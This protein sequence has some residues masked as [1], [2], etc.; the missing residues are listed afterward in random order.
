MGR[1]GIHRVIAEAVTSEEAE[2]VT[3]DIS[4]IYLRLVTAPEQWWKENELLSIKSEDQDSILT[5]AWSVLVAYLQVPPETAR[6]ALDWFEEKGFMTVKYSADGR[7]IE[8]SLEGLYF[9][10]DK[11]QG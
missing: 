2:K 4:A 9:P 1:F 11:S 10:P 8:I 3:P 6:R 5:L 7:Q